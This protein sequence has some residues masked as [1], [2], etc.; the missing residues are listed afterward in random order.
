ML[1]LN[2]EIT[3]FALGRFTLDNDHNDI[4]IHVDNFQ[5]AV[6]QA[7][8]ICVRVCVW[9]FIH[10]IHTSTYWR[11]SIAPITNQRS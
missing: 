4:D 3:M 7:T 5:Q 11:N 8:V 2:E 6:Y 9:V 10:T 1:W